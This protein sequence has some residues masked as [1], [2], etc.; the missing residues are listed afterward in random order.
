MII[1]LTQRGALEHLKNKPFTI[2]EGVQ[3]R[4]KVQFRVQHQILSGLKYVQVAKR[5]GVSNKMQEMIVGCL[6]T[7]LPPICSPFVQGSYSPN[8]TDKP[9]YEKKCT[10][11]SIHVFQCL[12]AGH[13]ATEIVMNPHRIL[14]KRPV[15][16]KRTQSNRKQRRRA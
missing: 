5:M 10:C 9:F 11:L 13:L 14:A 6:A 12:Q 4:M 2:K 16:D 7:F 1:D 15:A 3:F 8:T